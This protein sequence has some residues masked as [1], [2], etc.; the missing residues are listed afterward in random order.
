MPTEQ[1][2]NRMS[3]S[4]RESHS[5]QSLVSRCCEYTEE[6]FRENPMAATLTA[7]GIGVGLGAAIGMMIAEPASKS[8]RQTAEA[9]GRRMLDSV[10]ESL[11]QSVR[12]YV[13]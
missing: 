7:F 11:P 8:R 5:D 9:L 2:Q 4:S 3:P 6:S 12:R 1:Y 10:A 13:S